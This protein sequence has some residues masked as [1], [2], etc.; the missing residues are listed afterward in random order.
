MHLQAGDKAPAFDTE[1]QSGARHSLFDATDGKWLLLYFYPEDDTPGCTT[2][3]CG[4]RNVYADLKD[5]VVILGVSGDS[6]ESHQKFIEKYQLPFSLLIDPES[7]IRDAYGANGILFPKR[8][9][10][11]IDDQGTIQ[12]VYESVK[13]EEHAQEILKDIQDLRK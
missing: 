7:K 12:K 6:A 1:D 5:S 9:S 13:P 10:F 11:L 2:E 3:A 8:V 4:L